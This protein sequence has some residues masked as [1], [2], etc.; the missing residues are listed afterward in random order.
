MISLPVPTIRLTAINFSLPYPTLKMR[1][2]GSKRQS[3]LSTST[4]T[5]D[6]SPRFSRPAMIRLVKRSA[7]SIA[8]VKR[9]YQ[10]RLRR[11]GS[12]T[13]EEEEEEVMTIEQLGDVMS[14]HPRTDYSRYPSESFPSRS[15][16]VYGEEESE[17]SVLPESSGAS[18]RGAESV[19]FKRE[20]SGG[21]GSGSEVSS[22]V[23]PE[24]V[25]GPTIPESNQESPA[26]LVDLTPSYSPEAP[27]PIAV[28]AVQREAPSFTE[29]FGLWIFTILLFSI[30]SFSFELLLRTYI[31]VVLSLDLLQ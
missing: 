9:R 21:S 23:L 30:S 19:L 1:P 17:S 15:G 6:S 18:Y 10:S 22:L 11:A 14:F 7:Q 12:H 24:S 8:R 31:P 20:S 27:I 29:S 5:T 25:L 2:A 16:S 13:D 26:P 4:S 28:V 3:T